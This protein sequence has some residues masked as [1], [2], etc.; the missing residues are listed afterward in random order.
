MGGVGAPIPQLPSTPVTVNRERFFFCH[1][2]KAAGTSVRHALDNEFGADA[3]YPLP[4]DADDPYAYSDVERL[5]SVL[6]DRGDQI[7]LIVGH[8]PFC[9]TDLLG[10]PLTTF[11]LLR[12]PVART[13]SHLRYQRLVDDRYQGM[14]MLE[15]YSV[16]QNLFGNLHNQMVKT[17]GMA[18]E[19]N[20]A[21]ILT[22]LP[23]T[24]LHLERAKAALES[25]AVVGVQ[26]DYAGF[27]ED[28]TDTF[29]WKVGKPVRTNTTVSEPVD[30][31][32]L[33]LVA[34]DNHLDAALHDHAAEM[35]AE[36]AAK[37]LARRL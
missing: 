17:L 20:T 14:S 25:M 29:G 5:R 6:E 11:T 4:E 2:Q 15:A 31:S 16:P 9:I 18:A 32:F 3:I 28:L 33:D 24:E 23:C 34:R 37:R 7:E 26:S 22:F 1:I 27:L 36:R 35:E 8:F 19:E 10:V 13:L 30:Q 21:G 12:E